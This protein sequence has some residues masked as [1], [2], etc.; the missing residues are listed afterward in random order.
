MQS[1][2][3]PVFPKPKYQKPVLERHGD[4]SRVVGVP[5]SLPY[6]TPTIFDENGFEGEAFNIKD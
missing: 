3:P 4:Y 1:T 5:V 2:E 6:W